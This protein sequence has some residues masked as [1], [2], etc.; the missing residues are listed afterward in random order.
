MS[1]RTIHPFP[2]RMAPDSALHAI[3]NRSTG[4]ALTVLDPMCG[5]GTVLAAALQHGHNAVGVDIDPLAVMMSTLAVTKVEWRGHSPCPRTAHAEAQS[6][7]PS[8]SGTCRFPPNSRSTD[9]VDSPLG[10]VCG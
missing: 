1:A 5:S 9:D 2:A 7:S 4:P 6:R 3:P 8:N 10:S